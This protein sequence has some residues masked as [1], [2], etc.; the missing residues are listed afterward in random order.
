M[1]IGAVTAISV[2]SSGWIATGGQDCTIH[3]FPIHR[4]HDSSCTKQHMRFQE[5]S[6]PI[7]GLQLVDSGRLFSISKDQTCKVFDVYAE[8]LLASISFP[9]ALTSLAV[10]TLQD[11]VFV[12]AANGNVY[13]ADLWKL[14]HH[15]ITSSSDKQT[16]SGSSV[17]RQPLAVFAATSDQNTVSAVSAL[18]LSL[19]GSKLAVGYSSGLIAVWDSSSC[20]KLYFIQHNKTVVT[21]ILFHTQ[22]K[23][24][25]AL[26]SF[27]TPLSK[28]TA[29][30]NQILSQLPTHHQHHGW[31]LATLD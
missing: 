29:V 20:Q 14:A 28:D 30:P 12:G 8:S 9:S 15:Q 4:Q 16:G 18:S 3:V 22:S 5:H 13:R 21:H 31:Q 11:S 24:D 2:S 26:P 23:Q 7:V 1:H 25:S 17:K 10:H 6:L 19:D 27:L